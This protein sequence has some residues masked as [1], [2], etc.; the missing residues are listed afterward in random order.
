MMLCI[1]NP[2]HDLC[3]A[4]G[5]ALYIPPRSA[6]DFALRDS[7]LM[8]ILY[9]DALCCSAY[10]LPIQAIKQSDI[11]T[12]TPWGWN[13]T[14]KHQLLKAGAP[15]GLLPS[16]DRLATLRALQ[17]RTTVLPLQ[18]DCRAIY[19]IV[20][21]EALLREQPHWVLKAPW[22]GAGR[23]LRWLHGR[24]SEIDRNW[25]AKTVSAQ[26]CV[27][28]EPRRDVVADLAL[29]YLCTP[30]S[31]L[32][33]ASSPK[34][35][36]QLKDPVALPLLQGEYPARG[37]GVNFVGY[38]YFRTSHGVYKEN[39]MWSDDEIARH[40]ADTDLQAVRTR[41][42]Q[43]L[44]ANIL[45]HYHGPLGVDLMA[46]ADGSIHVA[47]LNLRHTMGMVAHERLKVI[48]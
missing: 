7:H 48:G 42:E 45:P 47:E 40:F 8:Q 5:R 12:I 32:C 18:P 33:T 29:E 15:A 6:R 31:V 41:V 25:I 46:C 14:L 13:P 38:S 20:E 16:D 24:L 23:G 27:I 22:S 44:A 11:Q 34:T 30:Q 37:E 10:D 36:E 28:A 21:A 2:E 43:W 9:P 19:N 1:F 39:V 4:S 35:G 26:R 17:H 3:L